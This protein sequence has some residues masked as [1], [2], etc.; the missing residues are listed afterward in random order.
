MRGRVWEHLWEG[1]MPQRPRCVRSQP[2]WGSGRITDESQV[3]RDP[4]L[5]EEWGEEDG[6]HDGRGLLQEVMIVSSPLDEEHCKHRV[7]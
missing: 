4:V 2:M 3:S 5:P 6:A 7:N 1:H